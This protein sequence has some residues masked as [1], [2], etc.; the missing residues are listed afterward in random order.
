VDAAKVRNW[1][2]RWNKRHEEAK[3]KGAKVQD[4]GMRMA[5]D[6]WGGDAMRKQ[7]NRT[8]PAKTVKRKR[9]PSS[10][11]K[12]PTVAMLE[13]T[14]VELGPC[15]EIVY[16]DATGQRFRMHWSGK[17]PVLWWNPEHRI[18]AVINGAE[19][20]PRR[21]VDPYSIRAREVRVYEAFH[22]RDVTGARSQDIPAGKLHKLG[23]AVSI[24]Y[25]SNKRSGGGDGRMRTY[26]HDFA[27]SDVL[28]SQNKRG[29][30]LLAVTG[31]RLTVNDRGI[32]Y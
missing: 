25:R 17:Q 22:G 13:G 7:A 3:R 23:R 9:N 30:S 21:A 24:A 27:P 28:W 32:V 4:G 11:A 8:A 2:A 31:P 10:S 18:L 14:G 1:F 29:R 6:L 12:R 26:E 15:R 5:W 19:P 16:E 20:P